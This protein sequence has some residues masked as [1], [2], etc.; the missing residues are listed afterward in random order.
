MHAIRTHVRG[1][2][3]VQTIRTS[4]RSQV[5]WPGRGQG[6]DRRELVVP[7]DRGILS[8]LPTQPSRVARRGW[9]ANS[10]LLPSVLPVWLMS[11]A[12]PGVIPGRRRFA[13]LR[14]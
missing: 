12:P 9:V 7:A 6:L 8:D 13:G 10:T 5:S 2:W 11:R 14:A 4:V 1:Q 3:E